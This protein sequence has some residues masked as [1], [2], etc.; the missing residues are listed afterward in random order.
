MQ[1]RH[2]AAPTRAQARAV[3]WL[4]RR[5]TLGPA[6]V[7]DVGGMKEGEGEQQRHRHVAAHLGLAHQPARAHQ[8]RV[9]VAARAKLLARG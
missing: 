9:Q 8:A 7:H 3:P 2:K 4:R 6:P 5:Y 1:H